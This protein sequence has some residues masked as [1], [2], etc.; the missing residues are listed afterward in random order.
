MTPLEATARRHIS[1]PAITFGHLTHTVSPSTVWDVR[2]GRFVYSQD[3][4]APLRAVASRFDRATGVTTGAPAR[5]TSS[6]IIRATAK[7]TV[8]HYRADVL[9][10]DHLW[11]AGGQFERGE[12]LAIG[13]IPTGVRFVDNNGAPFQAVS[14][15]AASLGGHGRHRVG[16]RQ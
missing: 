12:H 3:D 8:S 9:G 16:L 4:D 6:T 13:T 7:A 10:A 2:V 1:V 5:L 15:E 11:K 14:S